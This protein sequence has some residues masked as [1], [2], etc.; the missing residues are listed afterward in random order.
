L[1]W[2][3]RAKPETVRSLK[4]RVKAPPEPD[5]EEWVNLR[6]EV[7]PEKWPVLDEGLRVSGV[8][9]GA[10]ATKMQRVNTWGQE[11]LSS[12]AAPADEHADDILF[13][14]EDEL[15]P[16]KELLEQEGKPAMG[17]PR[18]GRAGQSVRVQ[19][20]EPMRDT[21]PWRIHE[22]LKGLAEK[23]HPLGRGVS[24]TWRCCSRGAAPGSPSVSPASAIIARKRAGNGRAHRGAARRA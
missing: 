17:G 20:R 16:L 8:V 4:V 19:R 10:T 22:E 15:E 21:I 9:V 1:R 2:I 3:L 24:G 13:A 14:P 23:A 5:E 18:D 12:H 7:S 11:Y 6:A